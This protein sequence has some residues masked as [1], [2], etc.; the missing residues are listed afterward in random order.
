[1]LVLA[2]LAET[3]RLRMRQIITSMRRSP[4]YAHALTCVDPTACHVICSAA[5]ATA[6]AGGGDPVARGKQPVQQDVPNGATDGLARGH[7][8]TLLASYVPLEKCP[9]LT[10]THEMVLAVQGMLELWVRETSG[11]EQQQGGGASSRGRGGEG[12]S[13]GTDSRG[14]DER[15]DCA[16]ETDLEGTKEQA[17]GRRSKE[18]SRLLALVTT[19]RKAASALLRTVERD[20]L[21]A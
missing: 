13:S 12:P 6:K 11:R 2:R 19:M 9:S 14:T 1:M 16:T 5:K 8:G 15:E 3:A 10:G 7:T 21:A 20:G 4:T 18:V 17:N